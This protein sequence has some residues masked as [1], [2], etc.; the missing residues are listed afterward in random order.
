MRIGAAAAAAWVLGAGAGHAAPALVAPIGPDSPVSVTGIEGGADHRA[1]VFV[2]G[3]PGPLFGRSTASPGRVDFAPAFPFEP[4]RSYRVLLDGHAAFSFR[5]PGVAGPA[6]KVVAIEPSAP[7]LPATTLRLYATFDRSARGQIGQRDVRL[8][9]AASGA[10]VHAPFM[11]FG[12]ELWSGD[13]RR[14]TLLFDPARIKRGVDANLAEGPPL[15]P[16]R[17]YVLTVAAGGLAY[18]RRFT[19]GPPLRQALRPRDWRLIAPAG[20]RQPVSLQFDRAMDPALVA[21]QIGVATVSGMAVGGKVA[22]SADDRTWTFT[23]AAAWTPQQYVVRVGPSLEDVSGN[24]VGEAL[25]HAVGAFH[26]PQR[27]TRLL[28]AVNRPGQ[29]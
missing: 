24:R 2:E 18:H 9:D 12:Q 4:G 21:D 16:G 15:A 7:V 8:L 22:I 28:F 1:Q 14:L 26:S 25:D 29:P 3:A 19:A 23:P 27:A 17:T 13:G 10:A 20:N 11:D 6:P 5:L